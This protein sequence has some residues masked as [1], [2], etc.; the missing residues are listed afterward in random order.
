MT[1]TYPP[2]IE[3]MCQDLTND[4]LRKPEN[5]ETTRIYVPGGIYWPEARKFAADGPAFATDFMGDKV[6]PHPD[7]APD[8][9][10]PYIM[11][12]SASPSALYRILDAV[13]PGGCFDFRAF[14]VPILNYVEWALQA[15]EKAAAGDVCEHTYTY[16][17][18]DSPLFF[19]CE[20]RALLGAERAGVFF[21]RA[22][23]ELR[24]AHDLSKC[25]LV[26][27]NKTKYDPLTTEDYQ[28][29][30]AASTPAYP[31]VMEMA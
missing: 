17:L 30:Y 10:Q 25:V 12:L 21:E 5:R 18:G 7:L 15:M 8:P 20:A 4:A 14:G 6:L 2:F 9:D 13:N 31:P 1:T 29:L 16:R 28:A 19:P 23:L 24:Q 26:Y 3:W 11:R 22:L 27:R